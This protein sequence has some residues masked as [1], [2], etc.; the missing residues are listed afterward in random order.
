MQKRGIIANFILL[1]IAII[2]IG[3]IIAY[4]AI[5]NPETKAIT[6]EP[7]K[8]WVP[9]ETEFVPAIE[10]ESIIKELDT[11]IEGP[12]N[13]TNVSKPE[14]TEIAPVAPPP[15]VT[16]PPASGQKPADPRIILP[17]SLPVQQ[18]DIESVVLVRCRFES[19][20]FKS[21]YQPWNEERYSLGSGVIV[22]A[23]G[24]ILTAKHIFDLDDEMK[25]D[26]SDR[27]WERTNCAIAQNDM[28]QTPIHPTDPNYSSDDPEFKNVSVVFEPSNEEYNNAN[29]LDF[30]LL[31]TNG[32]RTHYHK[33]EARLIEFTKDQKIIAIGYPGKIVSV[34]Q[35]LE[36]W[37]GKFQTVASLEGSTCSGEIEPCGLRYLSSRILKEY[38]DLFYKDSPLGIYSPFFRGGFS[39]APAFYNGNLIGIVTHGESGDKN[40]EEAD[41]VLVLTSF[42]IIEA[43]KK[44]QIV[45]TF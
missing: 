33:P 11:K 41:K 35:K 37:D 7:L 5:K 28:N 38:R 9:K 31:K 42:D 27:R 2:A 45:L 26:L 3:A 22:S 34:P 40:T 44:H 25:N 18:I 19:Q 6:P 12:K 8:T 21:S 10:P 15:A 24:H 14:Q 23:S 39:G 17:E 30:I 43:L 32:L 1:V 16:N 13:D 29:D 36:R 4:S 20:Y